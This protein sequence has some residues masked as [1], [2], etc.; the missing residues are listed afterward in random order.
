LDGEEK[1][2]W[3]LRCKLL[4]FADDVGKANVWPFEVNLLGFAISRNEKL[5]EINELQFP[6]CRRL[7]AISTAGL[8]LR[9]WSRYKFIED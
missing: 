5:S 6:L 8:P 1:Y 7:L 3:D 9:G 4:P 2:L